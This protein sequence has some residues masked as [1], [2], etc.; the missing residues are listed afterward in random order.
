[1]PFVDMNREAHIKSFE[2]VT[3]EEMIE[4]ETHIGKGRARSRLLAVAILSDMEKEGRTLA[5]VTRPY[6]YQHDL[7]KE[8]IE[9]PSG[10]I[11]DF[12]SIPSALW[13]FV[14]PFGRHAP[15]AVVHDYLYALQ[16]DGT[17]KY[18]DFIFRA[19]MADSG[20]SFLRRNLMYFAVRLFGKKPF[21]CNQDW[22]FVDTEFGEPI[23]PP[24]DKIMQIKWRKWRTYRK[25]KRISDPEKRAEYFETASNENNR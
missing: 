21:S 24:L 22:R 2:S 13:G 1:M 23:E 18:A 4:A 8:R 7:L 17:R 6:A 14:Q 25:G 16:Q 15:A 10:F 11:T 12:A 20:V 5:V 19:A 3:T 9:I